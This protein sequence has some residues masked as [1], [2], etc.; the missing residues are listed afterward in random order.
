MCRTQIYR[1][2]HPFYHD[3]HH[4]HHD[5]H[6][7]DL[8]CRRFLDLCHH[9]YHH[10]HLYNE[11]QHYYYYYRYHH[12]YHH[13]YHYH[14]HYHDNNNNDF[15]L[16]ELFIEVNRQEFKLDENNATELESGVILS[17][18]NKTISIGTPFGSGIR[19]RTAANDSFLTVVTAFLPQYENSSF[20]LTG[21]WNSIID[22]DFT[23]PNG[24]I[25]PIDLKE[26]E[27]FYQFG[28]ACE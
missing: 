10:H 24:T 7:H 13:H 5:D 25:L 3:Y 9:E 26:S 6:H 19:V 1:Y 18:F 23:L 4:D 11:Q 28:K 17:R 21:K 22:D 15:L 16:G 20:G 27:I 2:Y 14:Y 8:Y 12:H